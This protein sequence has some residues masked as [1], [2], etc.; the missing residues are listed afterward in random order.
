LDSIAGGTK[1]KMTADVIKVP[2][3]ADCSRVAGLG[4]CAEKCRMAVWEKECVRVLARLMVADKNE[5]SVGYWSRL[6][7][8][9]DRGTEV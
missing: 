6:R 5:N 8:G 4:A 1:G 3:T 2:A 9:A 7:I